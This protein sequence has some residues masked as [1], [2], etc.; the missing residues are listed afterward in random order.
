[1][2]IRRHPRVGKALQRAKF[3]TVARPVA[4]YS[5][6]FAYFG[7]R[8]VDA[9]ARKGARVSVATGASVDGDVL[10]ADCT[11]REEGSWTGFLIVRHLDHVNV[12]RRAAS[13]VC[14]LYCRDIA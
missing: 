5:S 9:A 7:A 11:G 4:R 2:V 1:M 13:V 8:L 12:M 6:I 10:A 3:G 14:R